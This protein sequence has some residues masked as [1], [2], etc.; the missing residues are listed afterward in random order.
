MLDACIYPLEITPEKNC[1]FCDFSILLLS[2]STEFRKF[3]N[4]HLKNYFKS[5]LWIKLRYNIIKRFLQ[6]DKKDV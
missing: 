2:W 5:C 4:L 1:W 6:E 3:L